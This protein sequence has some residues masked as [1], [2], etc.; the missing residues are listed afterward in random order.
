[1]AHRYVAIAEVA[2]AHGIKG[3]LRLH[4]YNPDSDLLLQRP[5]V[6][7]RLPDGSE[8]DFSVTAARPVNKGMLVTLS[9]IADRSQADALQ[10]ASVCV[11]R[12]MFPEPLDGEFYACDIEGADVVLASGEIVGRVQ[13]TAHYP[14]CDVLLV[15]PH[16][17]GPT[18]E[19]PLLAAYIVAIEPEA[20]RVVVSGLEGLS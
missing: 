16:A 4:L 17:G 12:D 14:T 18:L 7:L 2:R 10:G 9:G 20:N 15:Q 1:M 6:R 8:R 19:V 13:G 11:R 3:E 5:S